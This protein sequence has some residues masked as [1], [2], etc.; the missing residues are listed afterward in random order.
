MMARC[1]GNNTPEYMAR[2]GGNTIWHGMSWYVGAVN[3]YVG[4]MVCF[5]LVVYKVF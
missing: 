1:G 5:T 3:I 4:G 2:C